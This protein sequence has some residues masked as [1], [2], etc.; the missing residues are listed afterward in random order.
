MKD[1]PIYPIYISNIAL[2]VYFQ[3]FVFRYTYI[4]R[5]VFD[6][7]NNLLSYAVTLLLIFKCIVAYLFLLVSNFMVLK[8]NN[9]Y[10]RCGY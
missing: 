9:N 8:K 4:Y 2:F 6:E 5:A 3:I 1:L 10:T 7:K